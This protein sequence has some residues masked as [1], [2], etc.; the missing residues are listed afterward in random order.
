MLPLIV[1]GSTLLAAVVAWWVVGAILLP[2]LGLVLPNVSISD[3]WIGHY[4]RDAEIYLGHVPS[5]LLRTFRHM[6][7]RWQRRAFVKVFI[8]STYTDLQLERFLVYFELLHFYEII[9]MEY[10]R[11]DEPAS[12]PAVAN[13]TNNHNRFQK[14]EEWSKSG[15]AKSDIVIYLMGRQ[16]GSM[17]ETLFLQEHSLTEFELHWAR[18]FDKPLIAYR[19]KRPLDDDEKQ[20]ALCRHMG[21]DFVR[22][23]EPENSKYADDWY[24][25]RLANAVDRN[26]TTISSGDE[27]RQRVHHDVDQIQGRFERNVQRLQ[28]V[29]AVLAVWFAWAVLEALDLAGPIDRAVGL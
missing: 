16:M 1:L 15:V 4:V 27:L 21:Q 23:D 18:E 19:L 22:Q 6:R 5:R 11:R 2:L 20:R 24:L 25:L 14:A 26:I 28:L 3:R 9:G 29:L 13:W 17:R 12:N 10:D 7:R 8:S